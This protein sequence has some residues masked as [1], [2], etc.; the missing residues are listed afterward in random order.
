MIGEIASRAGG[1]P[2]RRRALLGL[3]VA[4]AAGLAGC[5]FTTESYEFA[6][7]LTVFVEDR[8]RRYQA[9]SGARMR[10]YA[11]PPWLAGSSAGVHGDM[12]KGVGGIAA[13]ADQRWVVTTLVSYRVDPFSDFYELTNNPWDASG[14]ALRALGLPDHWEEGVRNPGM[15]ELLRRGSTVDVRIPPEEL[16]IVVLVREAR[17]SQSM[18]LLDP[19][20][21]RPESE[22]RLLGGRLQ[23]RS[24]PLDIKAMEGLLPWL[25]TRPDIID[26]PFR[27][28][29][30]K[31]LSHLAFYWDNSKR[32]A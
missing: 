20:A 8:G 4:G 7:R 22:T 30:P 24:P 1:A 2:T 15:A 3:G 21:S 14:V 12:I 19:R 10:K 6:Y 29:E 31:Y 18:E 26:L 11:D 23:M 17:D 5:G 27:P 9:V 28:L 13:L 32:G 25:A 16:P